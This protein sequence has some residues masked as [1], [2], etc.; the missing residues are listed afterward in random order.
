M[1]SVL[2]TGASRGI[3]RAIVS[4]LAERG[5]DVF[6][7]VR[8]DVDA[9]AIAALSPRVSS[10]LLDVTD[11]THLAALDE[12]LPA[13]L[14]AVVNN[15]AIFLPSPLEPVS[16]TD[17]LRRQLEV[18]LIGAL[19]VTRAVLPRLRRSGGRTV[20]I[21]SVNGRVSFPLQ[22][23]YSASKFAL[24]AAV[25]ALRMELKPWNIAVVVV[26]PGETDTDI[27]HTIDRQVAEG[28]SA[29]SPEQRELYAPHIAGL[30]RMIPLGKKL[31]EPPAKV[32]AVVEKALTVRRPRARYVVGLTNKLQLIALQK[33]PV[34]VRDSLLRAILRQPGRN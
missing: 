28:V 19:A 27:W 8:N 21:S 31:V 12:A 11:G 33:S 9:T 13:H 6:A 1:P 10:V 30:N 3:G 16:A 26:Q 29:M 17:Q 24:E 14:D 2:V 15:A 7:G 4:H 23:A 20:F 5:W 18:N 25:D 32:A 22:G 34:V